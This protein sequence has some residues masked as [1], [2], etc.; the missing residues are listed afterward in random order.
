MSEKKAIVATEEPTNEITPMSLI[1]QAQAGNASVEHM[2]QLLDLQMRWE[3]NEAR[4]AFNVAMSR[5]RNEAPNIRKTRKAHNSTYAGLAE[6]VSVVKPLLAKY[7]LSHRWSTHQDGDQV[8]VTCTVSHVQGHSESTSLT[9]GHDKTGSKNSIQAIGSTVSYLERYSL[10]A[11]LG[12]ASTDHDD[13]GAAAGQSEAFISE[14]QSA[15]IYALLDEIGVDEKKFLGFM[16][17]HSV[18]EISAW[19]YDKAIAALNKKRGAK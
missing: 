6:S 8:T 5:F 1:Q 16:S 14:E 2:S 12:L 3:A 9:A 11:I 18:E 7:G 13:D 10:Y 15:T 4:K 17:A 19:Q